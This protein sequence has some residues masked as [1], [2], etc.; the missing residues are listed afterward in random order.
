MTYPSGY[1]P[2]PGPSIPGSGPGFVPPG[3]GFVPPGPGF[4]PPGP[5]IPGPVPNGLLEG[6]RVIGDYLDI[7]DNIGCADDIGFEAFAAKPYNICCNPIAAEFLCDDKFDLDGYDSRSRSESSSEFLGCQD[8]WNSDGETNPNVACDFY[9]EMLTQ[10]T[11]CQTNPG[12]CG[13]G[14]YEGGGRG[15]CGGGGC[16][17]GGYEGGG[18]E[19]GGYEGGGDGLPNSRLLQPISNQAANRPPEEVSQTLATETK[20]IIIRPPAPLSSGSSQ[21]SSVVTQTFGTPNHP[22]RPIRASRRLSQPTSLTTAT[23]PSPLSSSVGSSSSTT[24]KQPTLVRRTP[25]NH[26]KHRSI[27]PSQ[28]KPK[29]VKSASKL[30]SKAKP[31]KDPSARFSSKSNVQSKSN[32]SQ[33]PD[34]TS[35][36]SPTDPETQSLKNESASK[37]YSQ[38]NSGSVQM[39]ETQST[40]ASP[41]SNYVAS[42]LVGN[43]LISLYDPIDESA[44]DV[45]GYDNSTFVLLTTGNILKLT[46]MSLDKPPHQTTYDKTVITSNYRLTQIVVFAG[47]IY[48]LRHGELYQLDSRTYASQEWKWHVCSWAPTNIIQINTTLMETHLW[49]E[50]SDDRGYLYEIGSAGHKEPKL[51]E[52]IERKGHRR[53]YGADAKTYLDLNPTDQTAVKVPSN[54]Q[55]DKIVG[56]ALMH[57]GNII[58]IPVSLSAIIKSVRIVRWAPHYISLE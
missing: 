55:I 40:M 47:Y 51:R 24:S 46:P 4:V 20:K 34:W 33:L 37:S 35:P 9:P 16:G 22:S 17:E 38:S 19:G 6:P 56:G 18:Y 15:G 8:D 21:P 13:G 49:L 36:D 52:K 11:Q 54:D 2:G 30:T 23:V 43:Q 42:V 27:A 39:S 14:G 53:V 7:V 41:G 48:G 25:E 29:P 58:R 44:R 28:S 12:E 57:D 31:V 32:D 10:E 45:F 1:R 3:P 26:R 50:T 5:G